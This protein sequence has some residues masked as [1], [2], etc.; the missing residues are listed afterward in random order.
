M[1]EMKLQEGEHPFL[2]KDV[3]SGD[4]KFKETIQIEN[5]DKLIKKGTSGIEE[6]EDNFK[7]SYNRNNRDSIN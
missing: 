1:M 2:V 4:Y 6:I 5:G 7:R 3:V